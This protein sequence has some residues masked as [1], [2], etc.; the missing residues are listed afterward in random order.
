[1]DK[2]IPKS[3]QQ[4][5]TYNRDEIELTQFEERMQKWQDK[6]YYST[7]YNLRPHQQILGEVVKLI[8]D[9]ALGVTLKDSDID[10][11]LFEEEGLKDVISIF[12]EKSSPPKKKKLLEDLESLIA[13]GSVA[14]DLY[15]D[16]VDEDPSYDGPDKNVE[17]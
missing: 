17:W 1:M 5:W 15:Y 7:N 11:C 12:F 6:P 8:S 2:K 13:L 9:I 10:K 3:S 16:W 14:A 4:L